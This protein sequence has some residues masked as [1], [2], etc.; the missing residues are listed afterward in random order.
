MVG[1]RLI[2]NADDL[3]LSTGVNR[4]VI[5]GYTRGIVRRASLM[6]WAPAAGEAVKM[7][8]VHPNLQLGLH[9]DLCEWVY[10]DGQWSA[11]YERTPMKDAEAVE[12]EVLR[13][14][15]AFTRMVGRQPHHLDSH[16]H[17]H[18]EEPAA[19]LM[20]RLAQRLGTPLRQVTPG[21]GYCGEFYGQSGKGWSAPQAITVEA[22][23]TI[24]RNLPPGTTELCCHPAEFD[25]TES[26][27]AAERVVELACLC[28]P[29]VRST[30]AAEGI[31][32]IA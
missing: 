16:Q 11:V 8:K 1:R 28:D 23:Q 31:E 13:Q 10:R 2:V 6:V 26:S 25:D 14:L 5:I 17:V 32:L 27:Y 22:L 21:I 30:I 29:A 9:V 24:L 3:G 18:R 12:A 4:G 20:L 7:A 15:E 19:G